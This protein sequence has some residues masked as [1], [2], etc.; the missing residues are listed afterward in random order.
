MVRITKD[1]I[2]RKSEH[3][4]G[5]MAELEEIS[6]HQMEIEKIENIGSLCPKLKI[7]YLQNN[8]IGKLENLRHLKDLEYLN[9]A[10]N[11]IVKIEGLASCEFLNKL[12]LTVNF[13]DV[14]TYEASV[15]NLKKNRH[16]SDIYILGNPA[17]EWEGHRDYL[18]ARVPQ[19]KR[20]DGKAVTRSERIKA[21]QRVDDLQAQLRVLAVDKMTEKA[22]AANELPQPRATSGDDD[23]CEHTPEVRTE[24]YREMA[25]QKA[26]KEEEEKSEGRGSETM[27]Q[28]MR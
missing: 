18:I 24:I 14:D 13:I 25:E 6:S 16:L 5:T 26:E 4:E 21:A 8:I 2:R 7:L 28:S 22:A 1:I 9:V 12:D 10:L 23:L 11:N 15:A 20:I 17:C 3:N 19:L 27:P